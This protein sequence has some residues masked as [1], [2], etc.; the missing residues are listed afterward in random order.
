MSIGLDM[1]TELEHLCQV[2]HLYVFEYEKHGLTMRLPVI[3]ERAHSR[4][5]QGE[6]WRVRAFDDAGNLPGDFQSLRNAIS[7][8][9]RHDTKQVRFGPRG[10]IEMRNRGVS[11][12]PALMANVIDWLHQRGLQGYTV[13]RGMLSGDDAKTDD[14][15]LQRNR[16]YMKFGFELSDSNGKNGLEVT[17]GGFGAASVGAL[18]APPELTQRLVPWKVFDRALEWQGFDAKAAIKH[19][20]SVQRWH[21]GLG[22]FA[23]KILRKLKYPF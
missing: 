22:F 3:G 9:I 13:E 11:L 7:V 2:V 18:Q 1:E 8:V 14:D 4:N 23:R 20:E 10:C 15:R 5:G 12:G 19:I 21:K 16:F 17:E 6:M